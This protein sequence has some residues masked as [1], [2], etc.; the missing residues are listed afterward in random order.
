LPLRG[1][2]ILQ[3]IPHLAAGG[4]ER[5]TIEM[6][7]ALVAAGATALVV[8]AGGRLEQELNRV[9]GELIRLESAP[10]KNP[11]EIRANAGRIAKLV[12]ARKISL[13]HARSRAPAW[14]ALWAAR[15]TRLPFVTT[16]HGV[17]NAKGSLK[18]L[19]NSVMARGDKVIANSDYTAR[20]IVQEHPWAADR[21]VTIHRGVDIAKFSA[22]A[23]APAQRDGLAR[24]WKLEPGADPV[25]LLPGRLTGWKGHREAIAAAARLTSGG[26]ANWRMV[27]AGDPQGRDGYVGELK[28]LIA[29]H[30]LD[31]RVVMVG[32]CDDMPAAFALSDIVIAPSNEAE[33]FGRVAAEAGAMGIPAVGSSIGAQGEI[34]VDG[35]TGLIVPPADPAALS[36]AISK[37]LALGPNGRKAMG[38]AA[39]TR[40][41]ARFTTS[42]LQKATL[43]VYEGLLGQPR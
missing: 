13:I 29:S 25:I 22:D 35:T 17:Y 9:G 8:S 7:E 21:I 34:I 41:L 37:L 43:S 33:A 16:Y 36:T 5:T 2:T 26:V 18:R 38:Q 23:I 32:H 3:V 6:A 19:Y 27:F 30:G 4:A 1:A 28:Q 40:V 14:S 39:R 20:H 15:R 12:T 31:G 11:L 10:T 42:A 24:A